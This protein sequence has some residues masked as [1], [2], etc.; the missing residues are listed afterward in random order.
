MG[1]LVKLY[2]QHQELNH[3]FTRNDSIT[4]VQ[5]KDFIA[6]Y[7]L[8]SLSK[9]AELLHKTQPA[10]SHSLAKLEEKLSTQLVRRERGKHIDFTEEGHRFYKDISPLIDKLLMKIDE[11]ENKNTIT[12]GVPDDLDMDIQVGLFRDIAAVTDSRLRLICSFSSNISKM[13]ESGRISFGI[14]KEPVKDG[15]L[16][17]GWAGNSDKLT[18]HQ[19]HKLPLVSGYSGCIIRDLVE[20][21]LNQVGKD[22]Y[23]V[24]LSNR[25]QHRVQ[26]VSEGFGVG[27][28]STTRIAE[29]D[30]LIPLDQSQGFPKLAS[31]SHRT[32]GEAD[33][34]QKK[35][36]LPILNACTQLLNSR[37]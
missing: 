5:M 13:V 4:L 28:F 24:Y 15:L 34:A 25:I 30:T 12:V 23:F 6:V 29:S 35:Q 17:Y 36:I 37:A 14:I 7:E 1:K 21:T 32:V 11:T 26:A 19:H 3:F 22:F 8:R 9:A 20:K 10:I 18:F 27:V 31:F 33:T 2:K 16:H